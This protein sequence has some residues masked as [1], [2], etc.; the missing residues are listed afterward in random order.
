MIKLSPHSIA[1]LLLLILSLLVTGYAFYQHQK[2]TAL[3]STLALCDTN[4]SSEKQK[5]IDDIARFEKTISDT[6]HRIEEMK[7]V[8]D[9]ADKHAKELVTQHQ[10]ELAQTEKEIATYQRKLREMRRVETCEQGFQ[11][12]REELGGSRK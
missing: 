7:N 5:R 1:I 8:S 4:L 2:I 10:Q 9:L 6:N 3:T 11:L 12:L